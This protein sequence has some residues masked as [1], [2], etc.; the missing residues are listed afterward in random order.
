MLSVSSPCKSSMNSSQTENL[1]YFPSKKLYRNVPFPYFEI[2]RCL[3]S[4]G[5]EISVTETEYKN[6]PDIKGYLLYVQMAIKQ[7]FK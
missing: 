7:L 3:T 5:F 6:L 2:V 4:C 1:K